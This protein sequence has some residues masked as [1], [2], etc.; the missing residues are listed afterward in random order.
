MGGYVTAFH[1]ADVYICMGAGVACR[2]DSQRKCG[3]GD[4]SS[5]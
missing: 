1:S 2:D 4:M 5:L 3:V